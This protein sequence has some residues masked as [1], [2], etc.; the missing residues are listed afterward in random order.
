MKAMLLTLILI[1][2]GDIEL[3]L[4]AKQVVMCIVIIFLLLEFI[5]LLKN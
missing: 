2:S 3:E 5:L 4:N 1:Y